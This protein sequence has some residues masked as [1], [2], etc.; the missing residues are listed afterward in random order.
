MVFGAALPMDLAEAHQ[1]GLP[2]PIDVGRV[3][4]PGPRKLPQK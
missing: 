4:V 3:V 1:F 2:S